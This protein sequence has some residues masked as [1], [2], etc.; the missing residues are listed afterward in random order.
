MARVIRAKNFKSNFKQ[1]QLTRTRQYYTMNGVT[2][3]KQLARENHPYPRRQKLA[4]KIDRSEPSSRLKTGK[5][6]LYFHQLK[7]YNPEIGSRWLGKGK[8]RESEHVFV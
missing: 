4:V 7:I 1:R 6:Y 5:F 8:S 3:H 2:L